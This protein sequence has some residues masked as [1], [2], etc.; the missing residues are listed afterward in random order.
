LF[1]HPKLIIRLV[2]VLSILVYVLSSSLLA[3][4]VAWGYE[5]LTG[6]AAT[7]SAASRMTA[8]D[9]SINMIVARPILG[10]GYG[11]YDDAKRPFMRRVGDF[12]V[13]NATSHNTYLTI[14]AELGLVAFLLYM[15]PLAWW[16]KLSRRALRHLPRE[17]F[18]NRHFLLTLGLALL[19]MFVAS[20]FMDMRRFNPFGTTMWWM[21]L[22]LIGNLVYFHLQPNDSEIT[23]GHPANERF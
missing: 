12:A 23:Q 4:Q 6:E 8:N 19:H 2:I 13:Y 21:V 1:L 16:L 22:G 11:N 17:G 20:N 18:E 7:Q 9:A 3:D 14:M 10:W 5:R 15:L